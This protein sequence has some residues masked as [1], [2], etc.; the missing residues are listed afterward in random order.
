MA[1]HSKKS[2]LKTIGRILAIVV[3]GLLATWAVMEFIVHPKQKDNGSAYGNDPKNQQNMQNGSG[4]NNNNPSDDKNN[5]KGQD[6][7]PDPSKQKSYG[8]CPADVSG[9]LT[10]PLMD[11]QYIA[12]MLPLGNVSPPGHTF[13]VDHIYFLLNTDEQVPLYAPANGWIT[14]IMVNSAKK[15]AESDY[16][17]DSIVVTYTICDGLVLDFA[18]YTDL[19]QP[20]KDELAK[21]EN[22]CKSG[23]MKSG[24][25]NAGEQQ[26]DY[27]DLSIP[28]T[29][30]ELIGYTHRELRSDGG[31]Y[32]IPFEIWAANYNQ[33]SRSDVDW[34]YYEDNRYAHAVCTF[35]LYS[36]TLKSQF[37]AKFGMWVDGSKDSSGKVVSGIGAFTPRTVEPLCGEIVQNVAGAL[38]GAWFSTKPDLNDKSGNIGNAGYGITF[39][40]NNVDPTVGEVVIGGEFDNKM[41]GVIA[42][43]PTHSGTVNREPSEVKADGQV[44]CYSPDAN[45]VNGGS[46]VSD[47]ILIRMLD[48]HQIEAERQSGSCAEGESIKAVF[49]FMR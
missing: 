46:S 21:H 5:G 17:F 40:H 39:I 31:G 26:C 33:P 18:G 30:N 45:T 6:N 14:H 42:F 32:N 22:A 10:A 49:K 43:T 1:E 7:G 3:I 24:H 27:Q 12:A 23:I 48:E 2:P 29:S 44:Y 11:P 8:A 37:D 9:I 16:V 36:G 13:P 41:V 4:N 20:V 15:T 19:I 28:V 47:K 35:D 25:N 38:Q 34:S